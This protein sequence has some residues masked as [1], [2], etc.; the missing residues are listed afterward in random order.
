MIKN[1]FR[2]YILFFLT[3]GAR[4]SLEYRLLYHDKSFV[5][6]TSRLLIHCYFNLKVASQRFIIMAAIIFGLNDFGKK[7]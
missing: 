2:A 7:I 3:S 5:I 1:S 6:N 4:Q